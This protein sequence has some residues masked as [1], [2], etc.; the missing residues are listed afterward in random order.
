MYSSD[1]VYD[2]L[3]STVPCCSGVFVMTNV[4][5][6]EIQQEGKLVHWQCADY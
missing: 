5:H 3:P 4:T 1:E 2:L 6:K